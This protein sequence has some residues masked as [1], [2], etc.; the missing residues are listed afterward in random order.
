MIL[1]D[2][3]CFFLMFLYDLDANYIQFMPVVCFVPFEAIAQ[4]QIAMEDTVWYIIYGY[5]MVTIW[6]IY[7]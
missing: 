4:L 2:I 6:L 5:N 1:N 7:G 3:H